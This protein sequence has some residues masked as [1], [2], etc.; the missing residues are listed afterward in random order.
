MGDEKTTV[1]AK[2]FKTLPIGVYVV[3]R[4]LRLKVTKESRRWVFRYQIAGRRRDMGLGSAL[5]VSFK[6]ARESTN[7]LRAILA[8]GYDPIEYVKG[9]EAYE[10]ASTNPNEGAI[11]FKEFLPTALKQIQ[12][13]KQ[14]SNAKH[15]KQWQSTLE[16]YALPVLGE[17][18]LETI[19]RTEVLDVLT[20]IWF[21]KTETASRLRS[22][23]ES[24]FSIAIVR[25]L[26]KENPATWRGNLS[27][28]LPQPN[29]LKKEKHHDALSFEETRDLVRRCMEKQSIGGLCLVFGILTATR[30]NEY[31]RAS[32]DEV[33]VEEGVWWLSAERMK[34]RRPHR[35]PLSSWATHV[36]ECVKKQVGENGNA[37]VFPSQND[38]NKPLSVETPRATVRRITGKETTAHGFRST[39]RD[40]A[41]RE[42]VNPV[43]SEKSLAHTAGNAVVR[44]YQRDDL[45]EQRREILERWA[46][47]LFETTPP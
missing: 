25:G 10:I 8:E 19:G 28:F 43:L 42:G 23:L 35:V 24:V 17:L 44:A 40:W 27:A 37:F 2:N 16:T 33:N 32:W 18:P 12:T 1:T 46:L 13:V 22:R 30:P 5:E 20:P 29:K 4:G 47:A 45:L 36:L 9:I 15:A 11:T 31:A 38:R 21:T 14:W 7:K 3:G 41:E 39:F 26:K 6:E 34:A